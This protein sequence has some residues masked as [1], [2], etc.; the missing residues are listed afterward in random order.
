MEGGNVGLD[1]VQYVPSAL[2]KGQALQWLIPSQENG[3]NTK[4]VYLREQNAF[5][6][7][8]DSEEEIED[9]ISEGMLVEYFSDHVMPKEVVPDDAK[10]SLLITNGEWNGLV[11]LL[12]D[13]ELKTTIEA[14]KTG[15]VED[16]I[17]KEWESKFVKVD[18]YTL[19]DLIL[20]ANE[21]QL[22]H[23]LDLTT[24]TLGNLI[25][26][27]T[28]EE[29]RKMFN[30]TS[31]YTRFPITRFLVRKFFHVVVPDSNV[32]VDVPPDPIPEDHAPLQQ[33]PARQSTRDRQQ[34]EE[35]TTSGTDP[36]IGLQLALYVPAEITTPIT[37]LFRVMPTSQSPPVSMN[38]EKVVVGSSKVILRC[39][40]GDVFEQH[41]EK[42]IEYYEKHIESCKNDCLDGNDFKDWE[43]ESVKVDYQTLFALILATNELQFKQL[44]ELS[45]GTVGK[46]M[47]G[48]TPQQIRKMFNITLHVM[49]TLQRRISLWKRISGLLSRCPFI[50]KTKI[51]V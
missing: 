38:M 36:S 45:A 6:V 4:E 40:N 29:I 32:H 8:A 41:T 49:W 34:V 2:P 31:D 37:R 12:Q 19:F 43:L 22:K 44:Y 27:K 24:G 1:I 47:M 46:M 28:V 16:G 9:D 15:N 48:K 14:R 51:F 17:I 39:S 50:T 26:G 20:V 10:V 35:L 5:Q 11:N 3:E 13:S 21:L 18:H 42:V 33:E 23:L 30:I 25:Q 7:L